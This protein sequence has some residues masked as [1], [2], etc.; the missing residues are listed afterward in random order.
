[1]LK[2]CR[3]IRATREV[4]YQALDVVGSSIGQPLFLQWPQQYQPVHCRPLLRHSHFLANRP[5][6]EQVK[7]WVQLQH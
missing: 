5:V 2:N 6:V 1:M 7:F 4:P 3:H